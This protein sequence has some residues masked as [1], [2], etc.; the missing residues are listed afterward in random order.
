MDDDRSYAYLLQLSVVTNLSMHT[1]AELLK[2]GWIFENNEGEHARWVDPSASLPKYIPHSEPKC[3]MTCGNRYP[4]QHGLSCHSRCVY[5]HGVCHF[6]C[7]A[8]KRG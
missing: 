4:H 6:D 3:D 1:C 7:P 2:S 5:C 8:Y